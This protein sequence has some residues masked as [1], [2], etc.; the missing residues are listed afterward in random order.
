MKQTLWLTF[1]FALL[2]MCVSNIYAQNYNMSNAPIHACGG[3]FLDSGGEGLF[4]ANYKANENY[5]TTICPNKAGASTVLQFAEIDL[6]TKGDV[7][8]FYDGKSV[9]DTLLMCTSEFPGKVPA[10]LLIQATENNA[11]GCITVKFK[12]D[13]NGQGKGWKAAMSCKPSCQRIEAVILNTAPA[14]VPVDTG[15]V[16]V[17]PNTEILFNATSRFPQNNL[18]YAQSET[19]VKYEWDFADGSVDVGRAMK[20]IFKESGGYYVRLTVIDQFGCK[21]SNEEFVRVRVAPKPQF[22]IGNLPQELCMNDTISLRGVVNLVN[23]TLAISAIPT[24]ADFLPKGIR[25]DSLA[26]PDGDGN[27]YTTS[28]RFTQFAPGQLMKSA[29]DIKKLSINVEHSWAR[30]MEISIKCPS[31]KKVILHNH[32]GERGGEVLLG[33]P[34]ELDDDSNPIVPKPGRGAT[35]NWTST[36]TNPSWIDFANKNF[37][38]AP[39]GSRNYLPAGDYLPYQSFSNLIGCPLNGDWQLTV[40][41][42][43]EEDNGYIFSWGIQ[44]DRSLYPKVETFSPKIVSSGWTKDSPTAR[45]NGNDITAQPNNAGTARYTFQTKDDYQCAFDTSIQFKV[46][47]QTH[48]NC[49]KCNNN[50]GDIKNTAICAG[51]K[52]ALDASYTGKTAFDI[53]F[54]AHP[55]YAFGFSNHP[56]S[57]EYAAKMDVNSIF[58]KKITDAKREIASVCMDID[59]DKDE[60]LVVRLQSPDGKEM[61]L[62]AYYGGKGKN[63]TRTCFKPAATVHIKD[64][65]APFTGDFTPV[66]AWSALDG[67]DING[68][69]ALLLSDSAGFDRV[70]KLKSWSIGFNATNAVT[71]NWSPASTLS[72]VNCPKPT[73]APLKTVVY[74]LTANDSYNCKYTDT[75]RIVVSRNYGAPTIRSKA[76]KKGKVV[77]DWDAMEDAEAYEI[78]INGEGWIKPNGALSHSVEKATFGTSHKAQLRVRQPD[79][80]TCVSE[81]A[82]NAM[83][84][85]VCDITTTLNSSKDATC[86]G[87]NDGVVGLKVENGISPYAYAI[88]GTTR[89]ENKP[90][91]DKLAAGKYRIFI[92]DNVNCKDT[93]SVEVKQP[94]E[95]MVDIKIDSVTCK[96]LSTGKAVATATGGAGTYSYLWTG[97]G[98][99]SV[100][101]A[102]A[103][104]LKAQKYTL[105]TKDKNSCESIKDIEIFEPKEAL[106]AVLQADSV[107]CNGGTSGSIRTTI[108]GGTKPYL[109][110]WS[111]NSTT[112]D[113]TNVVKGQYTLTLTDAHGCKINQSVAVGEP[114]SIELTATKEN[115]SC[116][117]ANDGKISVIAVGG[118]PSYTFIWSDVSLPS[119][120]KQT[121]LKAGTYSITVQDS[122]GCKGITQSLEVTQPTQIKLT[123]DVTDA[124][125]FDAKNGVAGVKVAGGNAPYA[126]QWNVAAQTSRT[127]NN[128]GQG[129]Y[130]VSVTDAKKCTDTLSLTVGAPSEIV[131]KT[132]FKGTPCFDTDKG[133]ATVTVTG[134]AGNNIIKWSNGSFGSKIT[135]LKVGKYSVTATDG[136]GCS[137]RDS[138]PI[139]A[140]PLLK[141]DTIASSN[142]TCNNAA[143]G[144]AYV[145][146]KGGALPYK[147]LWNDTNAQISDTAK[148]LI[149]GTYRV[150][151]TDV[152][153]C[154]K[155]AST[156]ITQPTALNLTLKN[157][158]VRCFGGGDGMVQATV[159]GGVRGYKYAWSNNQLDSLATSL[160]IGKYTLT[161]TD[162]NNCTITKETT[163]GAPTTA[164][165]AD[166]TQTKLGCFAAKQSEATV[167]AEGGT[168]PYQYKWSNGQNIDIAT[169][170]DSIA[171]TVITTDAN[172]CKHID[173][174]KIEQL[175]Q[176]KMNLAYVKPTCFGEKDGQIGINIITG[177]VGKDNPQNYTYL[178]NNQQN[179]DVIKN[180]AG[181]VTYSVIAT[182][183]QGCTGRAENKLLQPQSVKVRLELKSVQ[184]FGTSTGE[185]S[186]AQVISDN[187]IATYK[188]SNNANEATTA[189]VKA[190]PADT[191]T[192]TVTDEKGCEGTANIKLNE[193][194]PLT[195]TAKIKSNTCFADNT[196]AITLIPIGG[197]PTYTYKWA[198]STAN[199]IH[200]NLKAGTYQFTV[201]DVN[202]CV[203]ADSTF[204][205]EP[206]QI[207]AQ[208]ST[209]DVGCYGESSGTMVVT[210]VGGTPPYLYSLNDKNFNENFSFISLKV[211]SYNVKIK[212]KNGCRLNQDF[213]ING[214]IPVE[215]AIIGQKVIRLGESA[216]FSLMIRNGLTKDS[217]LI[218]NV[219]ETLV[220]ENPTN[221]G[222]SELRIA[223]VQWSDPLKGTLSCMDCTNP[224]A[225]PQSGTTY[226]VT[227][228]DE[229]GCKVKSSIQI[230]VQKERSILVPTA[231]SPDDNGENDVLL[232]HGL[233]D[234]KIKSFRIFDRWGELIYE[235]T[236]FDING[237][238]GW[239]G[240]YRGKPAMTGTYIWVVEAEYPDGEQAMSKGETMLLR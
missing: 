161:V 91:I 125:C 97:V 98:F 12:S 103:T 148:T 47:P 195:V 83:V 160:K 133:E 197:T 96:G 159:S 107:T 42:L 60:D 150:I 8:C 71:Y 135:N 225:K 165:T 130:K 54:E 141:I 23:T 227:M 212:D 7:L 6:A 87:A 94:T 67:A 19:A 234:V 147:Y 194:K 221:Q 74:Q 220:L 21:N 219:P 89:V 154:T 192:V 69:W 216:T 38:L 32:A 239:D 200:T 101:T 111:N 122:K 46:L 53:G 229:N 204:L 189:I 68:T 182:D 186:V 214:P 164:L 156:T 117:G 235:A 207:E 222:S 179:T 4:F 238:T 113:V 187:P 36:A 174:L 17:C 92:T 13:S 170:L 157:T 131:L 34:Y 230:T 28:V 123:P 115:V 2:F 211:G 176:I 110:N 190:L 132:D 65:T 199:E 153:G 40:R 102:T 169:K 41:D 191:Y 37:G 228:K 81:V 9:A 217:F 58:P 16:N 33:L 137:V 184:C 166:A 26:L 79:G 78:N 29:S 206:Q 152:N 59:T 95:I 224:N 124:R 171:Y 90:N 226:E 215:L 142:I 155:N 77:F 5:T 1:V 163:I 43:W 105:L 149:P 50:Y 136:Q 185:V 22:T 10:A 121:K 138:F 128:V 139:N 45:Q 177:G 193:P 84:Y 70:G 198:D 218:N 57:K 180:L 208:V 75:A 39:A 73:A 181:D 66:N 72:C 172:N 178:W 15:W 108:L 106:T 49:Y 231:F 205:T 48:P 63:Y 51:D 175:D 162:K 129:K 240:L 100:L 196:G 120:S 144:R 55:N 62:T 82:A 11:S 119:D 167:S 118:R 145:R 143:N 56:G 146:V 127:I 126:Y 27:T 112:Q 168:A 209:T 18:K 76:F 201:T 93:I 85:M 99:P 210:P 14:T 236:D 88:E 203:H 233:P 31:G 109:Y 24:V 104:N 116:F 151:V 25:S 86:F 134:G 140:P 20:H 202:G 64:G 61:A 213:A 114:K 30:D 44:L 183:R 52:L 232:V 223:S 3:N 35:Y 237:N 188:W 80:V 158:D 173:T